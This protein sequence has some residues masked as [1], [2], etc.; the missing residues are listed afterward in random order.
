MEPCFLK[1]LSSMEPYI[2]Y[3]EPARWSHV[4]LEFYRS[5]FVKKQGSIDGAMFFYKF[6]GPELKKNMT[7]SMPFF[8]QNCRR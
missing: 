3:S 1:K 2:F 8:S 5:K 4:F 6:T 7:S